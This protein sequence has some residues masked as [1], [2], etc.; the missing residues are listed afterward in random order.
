LKEITMKPYTQDFNK[1]DKKTLKQ[2]FVELAKKV[3][4]WAPLVELNNAGRRWPAVKEGPSTPF[5]QALA[6]G[7]AKVTG[8]LVCFFSAVQVLYAAGWGLMYLD[9]TKGQLPA[10]AWLLASDTNGFCI[11]VGFV[12]LI[13]FVLICYCV[14]TVATFGGWRWPAALHELF[15]DK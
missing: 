13:L 12:V 11:G 6:V 7:I 1:N 3:A 4:P 9:P 5:L 15:G 2:R 8:V 10:N 14:G